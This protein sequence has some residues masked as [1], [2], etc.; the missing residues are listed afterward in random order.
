MQMAEKH[1][2][3]IDEKQTEI[4]RKRDENI[5]RNLRL[6]QEKNKGF[7][8]NS[9]A[10]ILAKNKKQTNEKRQINNNKKLRELEMKLMENERRIK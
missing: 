4:I 8:E 9:L 7:E 5:A 6:A 10:Y 3:K 1:A 2:I